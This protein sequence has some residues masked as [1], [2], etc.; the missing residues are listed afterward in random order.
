MKTKTYFHV[1]EQGNYGNIASHG[2]H[3]KL[4]DAQREVNRL[5][6]FFPDLHFYVFPDS[7]KKEPN[8]CTM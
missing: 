4:E 7:S 2:F 1:I 8:F 6:D 3:T 5:Q